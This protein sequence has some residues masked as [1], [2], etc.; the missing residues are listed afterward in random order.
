M[1]CDPFTVGFVG[2]LFAD[3]GK[4]VLTLGILNVGQ[5]FRSFPHQVAA[6]AQQSTGGAH[7]WR[8]HLGLGEHAASE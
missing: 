6:A 8:I 4:M 3:L 2:Q 5:K 1:V 7:L